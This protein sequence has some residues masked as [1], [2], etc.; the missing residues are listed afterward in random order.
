VTE[1]GIEAAGAIVDHAERQRR[2][3][4]VYRILVDLARRQRDETESESEAGPPAAAQ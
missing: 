1:S 2:L 4:K 3:G